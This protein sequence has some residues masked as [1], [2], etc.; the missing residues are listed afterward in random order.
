MF[1]WHCEGC[2]REFVV[3]NKKYTGVKKSCAFCFTGWCAGCQP[4]LFYWYGDAL[5]KECMRE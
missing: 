3:K 5:C 2:E 4:E 1:P